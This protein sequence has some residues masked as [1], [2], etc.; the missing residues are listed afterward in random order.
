MEQKLCKC[1]DQKCRGAKVIVHLH[2]GHE[3]TQKTDEL[4]PCAVATA[5]KLGYNQLVHCRIGSIQKGGSP[6]SPLVL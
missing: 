6:N 3:R 5:S 4:N 1:T 2:A